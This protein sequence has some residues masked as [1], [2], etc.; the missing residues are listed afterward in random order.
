MAPKNGT[1]YTAIDPPPAVPLTGFEPTR[2]KQSEAKATN[3]NNIIKQY[4]KTGVLPTIGRDAVFMDVSAAPDYMT[5]L[6]LITQAD[7]MF[8]QLP[9][10]LRARF[11]NE[12]AQFLDWT[13]DPA[14]R[15]EMRELGLLEK[16]ADAVRVIVDNPPEP[17]ADPAAEPP[18]GGA[19]AA[20]ASP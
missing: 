16:P 5:A 13:S 10:E 7:A 8:M 14:N 12:P 18:A 3:I 11:D 15:D 20:P 2:T 17:V 1:H 9:A 6:N 4:E 19:A